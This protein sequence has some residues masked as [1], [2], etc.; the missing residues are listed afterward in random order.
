MKGITL[1]CVAGVIVFLAGFSP[2]AA[3]AAVPSTPATTYGT[4]GGVDAVARLGDTIY[5]G[6][7][8]S[9]VGLATGGGAALTV[10]NGEPSDGRAD[11]AMPPVSGSSHQV[12]VVAPD[13][14]GGWYI[15]GNFTHVGGL[16]R[17]NIAHI[18]PD[19]S[20]DP[21]FDPNANDG[22]YGLA[23]SGSTVYVSGYFNGT[24]SIGGANRNYIAAL[25]ATTGVATSWNPNASDV[26]FTIAVSG[27]TVYAGGFF[28]GPSSIGGA[29]RN[30]I[31][32]LD[33]TTGLA[34][35]WNPN[36]NGSVA[37][38]AV[39]GSTVYAGGNFTGTNSIGG[40]DRNHIAALDA[41]T[42]LAVPGWDPN[43]NGF[44]G[45]LAVSGSTVYAGGQFSGASSIGGADRNYIA[46]LDATS[47]SATA[48]NPNAN[49]PVFALAVSGATVY[50]GGAFSGASS[51]GGADRN[52][53][54]GL[55]AT[56]GDATSW[57]PNADSD[58]YALAV[59]GSTVYAGGNFSLINQ[60]ARN[61]LAAFGAADGRVTSW[62]PNADSIVYSLAASGSTIYAGG[63]FSTIGGQTRNN[64]AAIDPATGQPT[65]W[66]PNADSEVD[67]LAVSGS[68]VYAGGAFSS[69]GGQ[70][71]SN[72]AA[73]DASSG[74]ATSW[75]PNADGCVCALAV[76]GSIV[77]AG[78]IFTS[79]GGQPRSDIAALDASSGN[80]T[81]WNPSSDNVVFALALDGSTVYAG[82]FFTS[83]GGQ[84]RS[85]IAAL[86]AS[87]GNATSWDP[88]ASATIN[89]LAV[90]G[91]TVYAGGDFSGT[92]SIGGADR[93]HIAA[94]DASTGLATSW[95]P[96][97]DEDVFALAAVPGALYAGGQFTSTASS[98]VSYFAAFVEVPGNTV[99]PSISG[100]P[101][102][103]HTLS[104]SIGT[105]SGGT[106]QSYAYQWLRDN[107][108]I[109]AQNNSTYIVQAGD[110]G[111]AIR[112]RV[113]ATNL[114]GSA[115]ATSAAVVIKAAPQNTTA[116][117]IA[118]T[119]VAGHTLTC[120][121]GSWTGGYY[122]T[123]AYKW[124]R[125]NV[126]ITG[127]TSSTYVVKSGDIG[128][129]LRCR[130]TASNVAGSTMATSAAV[131]IK[132]PPKNTVAPKITGIP[133]VGKTLSCSL[134]T[135]TGST[136]ITY[137]RQWLRGGS[138]I[139]GATSA[140][141]VV[142]AADKGKLLSC[143]VTAKNAAGQATKTSAAVKVT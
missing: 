30:H 15:G 126:A 56:T 48:W 44:V 78:G 91:S 120:H 64:I 101:S 122:L 72:I 75:D 17:N 68:T 10:A 110:A 93:N 61:N 133:K 76:S 77:Y 96:N 99:L 12:E 100:T 129:H 108:V 95:D 127:A 111:H 83:I 50:A 39:A 16:V 47:G 121:K 81:S 9:Q 25:N 23:V 66:D 105:W 130:V 11:R 55:D 134:G 141:Y 1:A 107:V 114:G 131:L 40:A 74:N 102:A 88:N 8:F 28:N 2:A 14:S 97:A 27:S 20:V 112:C 43:A 38:L 45:A 92:N 33:A 142:K 29:D 104:C 58:G 117:S 24:N 85:N 73:L 26:V 115:S 79:I 46:A 123:Y 128:K 116:P 37:T 51:I 34:T 98:P 70:P 90:S 137:S 54:A 113:T 106:P 22:V 118:G 57:D 60:V 41:T 138:P 3:G 7:S 132:T 4:N 69:I 21:N 6:G 135:W 84:P 139:A 87:T 94:L 119:P 13:G 71:R 42:G 109:G 63:V 5:L 19:K 52:H 136:P 103:G 124:L 62:D 80:A 65:N 82:G 36:A 125:N 140:S 18:L 89:A 53:L 31:A 67:A 143:R 59:S 86:D 32:A 35:G 49:S